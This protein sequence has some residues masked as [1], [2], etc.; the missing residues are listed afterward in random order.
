MGPMP[1]RKVPWKDTYQKFR[2]SREAQPITHIC[3]ISAVSSRMAGEKGRDWWSVATGLVIV[4]VVSAALWAWLDG[5][6]NGSFLGGLGPEWLV[7]V[8][9]VAVLLLVLTTRLSHSKRLPRRAV[10]R[11]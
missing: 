10:S 6:Y 1:I 7:A 2:A 8:S 9:V 3:R 11:H 4:V 5:S